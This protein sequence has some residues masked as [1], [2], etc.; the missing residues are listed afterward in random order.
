MCQ[1][2]NFIPY[3]FPSICVNHIFFILQCSSLM[4]CFCLLLLNRSCHLCQPKD[5]EGREYHANS[6]S[7]RCSLPRPCCFASNFPC[8]IDSSTSPY[9]S[10]LAIESTK[11]NVL[12]LRPLTCMFSFYRYHLFLCWRASWSQKASDAIILIKYSVYLDFWRFYT[13]V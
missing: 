1:Y 9:R 7:Q 8:I 11:E 12:S 10:H 13:K 3:L 5:N 6:T 2:I 4:F